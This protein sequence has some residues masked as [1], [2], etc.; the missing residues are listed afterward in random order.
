MFCCNKHYQQKF[1]E[2]LK[3]RLFN[4]YIFSNHNN[5]KFILLLWK[6]VSPYEYMDNCQRLNKTSLCEK[7]DFYSHLN[8]GDITDDYTHY[9]EIKGLGEY[10]DLHLQ[11]DTLSLADENFRNMCLKIYELD[12]AK[13]LSAPGLAW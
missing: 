12:P 4:T 2:K 7:E 9:F 11:S 8:M 6:D 1:D 10:H 3:E 13:F 5:N